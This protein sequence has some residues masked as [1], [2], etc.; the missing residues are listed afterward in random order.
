MQ[1]KDKLTHSS[2]QHSNHTHTQWN[3][4]C[5]NA[6][7]MIPT[8]TACTFSMAWS[9]SV[10][11]YTHCKVA[12]TKILQNFWLILVNIMQSSLT[13]TWWELLRYQRIV[14]SQTGIASIW[15]HT[16]FIIPG[17]CFHYSILKL[18]HWKYVDHHSLSFIKQV[19]KLG[20]IELTA[21]IFYSI[22]LKK[23]MTLVTRTREFFI[24]QLWN[25]VANIL[26]K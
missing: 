6:P 24:T 19:L 22:N 5:V 16:G 20:P 23:N 14:M 2:V 10:V 12:N 3:N 18:P 15:S 11:W 21:Q 17:K 7:T 25:Q 13:T 9:T 4:A 1:E 26:K 8:T